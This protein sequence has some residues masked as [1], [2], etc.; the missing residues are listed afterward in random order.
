MAHVT[1]FIILIAL[2]ILMAGNLGNRHMSRL[3]GIFTLD[4]SR[5]RL[6]HTIASRTKLNFGM[7]VVEYRKETFRNIKI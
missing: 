1:Q 6:L 5:G 4:N 2:I 7:L 3:R